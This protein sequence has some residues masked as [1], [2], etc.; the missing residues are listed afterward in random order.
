MTA[1]DSAVISPAALPTAICIKCG[2]E[3]NISRYQEIPR[4]GYVCPY[5]ITPGNQK[6]TKKIERD[7]AE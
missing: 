2:L 6:Q 4:E 1:K 7:R 5:C 3:W